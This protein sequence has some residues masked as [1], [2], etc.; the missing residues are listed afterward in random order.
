MHSQ[1]SHPP[2]VGAPDQSPVMGRRV[3]AGNTVAATLAAFFLSRDRA[4][5]QSAADTGLPEDETQ[6]SVRERM[7]QLLREPVS[8]EVLDALG[9][10]CFSDAM[11]ALISKKDSVVQKMFRGLGLPTYNT[12]K[13]DHSRGH[14]EKFPLENMYLAAALNLIRASVFSQ[15][16]REETIHEFETAVQGVLLLMGLTSVARGVLTAS[17]VSEMA[18]AT[19]RSIRKDPEKAIEDSI[20]QLTLLAAATQVPLTSFGNAAIGNH[21]FK[22]VKM[23]YKVIY[24]RLLPKEPAGLSRQDIVRHIQNE[25]AKSNNP[26]VHERVERVLQDAGLESYEEFAGALE[27][28]AIAHTHDLMTLLM[29]TS[30]DDAQAA[31]GDPGP[32][33]GLFQTFGV[34][35]LQVIP[36]MIPFTIY[37]GV[38][39][40]SV[41]AK[42][43]GIQERV[44]NRER[45][46]YMAKFLQETWRNLIKYFATAAPNISSKITGTRKASKVVTDVGAGVDFSLLEQILKDAESAIMAVLDAIIGSFDGKTLNVKRVQEA[47]EMLQESNREWKIKAGELAAQRIFP[48]REDAA[49]LTKE[50]LIAIQHSILGKKAPRTK[51]YEEGKVE[52]LSD[53]QIELSKLA[54]VANDKA[55][56]DFAACLDEI[57]KTHGPEL[58]RAIR[59]ALKEQGKKPAILTAA[60][61]LKEN[62]RISDLLDFNYWHDRIGPALTDTMFIVFLQGLHMPFLISTTERIMY[63]ADWFKSLPL[64]A[65]EELSIILNYVLGMFADN[66]ADTVAHSKWLATLYFGQLDKEARAALKEYPVARE[67]LA[68]GYYKDDARNKIPARFM[69]RITQ[70]AAL[71][72]H[73]KTLHRE[74][75]E[76]LEAL[77]QEYIENA[78]KYYCRNMVI[79]ME[80]GVIGAGN[81]LPG[82]STHFTFAAGEKDFTFATTLGDFK[83]HP[84][85]HAYKLIFGS[86][87]A[88]YLGPAMAQAMGGGVQKDMKG[89]LQARFRSRHP[90]FEEKFKE[91]QRQ[92]RAS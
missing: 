38:E 75:A 89:M 71:I 44:I 78:R 42:R 10:V 30:C 17:H 47:V 49:T 54:S 40:A 22:E 36:A 25:L 41:A 92:E 68:A 7:E 16:V 51:P 28:E 9:V 91:L 1:S 4:F 56:E 57:K 81:S 64:L 23:A 24:I 61:V 35:F 74:D 14:K 88:I 37:I 8:L 63:K 27:K 45:M 15:E 79:A 60:M 58:E 72:E 62:P 48:V 46:K 84:L 34:D 5:A 69:G 11:H 32:L 12:G 29:A 55:I 19:E 76:K 3:F 26:I 33:I 59:E 80:I 53:L 18:E 50:E 66:W 20:F 85:F 52:D 67:K 70:T 82:D 31:A 21:E 65:Q 43:A 90:G 2:P 73:L 13:L 83:R 6:R 87:Y 77:L 39:R 86:A